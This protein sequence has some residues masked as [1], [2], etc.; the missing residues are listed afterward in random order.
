[1]TLEGRKEAQEEREGRLA[2]RDS[3]KLRGGGPVV[4]VVMLVM[5]MVGATVM[6]VMGV[7]TID[8]SDGGGGNGSRDGGGGD[9]DGRRRWLERPVHTHIRHLSDSFISPP[10]PSVFPFLLPSFLPSHS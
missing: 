10:S 5:A 1:M 3:W 8:D 6:V 7:D 4:V 2:L 9:G